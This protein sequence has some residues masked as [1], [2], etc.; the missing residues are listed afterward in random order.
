MIER[1]KEEIE[2]AKSEC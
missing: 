1:C 2:H